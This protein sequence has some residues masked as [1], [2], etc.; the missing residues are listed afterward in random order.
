M[1]GVKEPILGFLAEQW[2]SM[3]PLLLP[4]GMAHGPNWTAAFYGKAHE[5]KMT[6]TFLSGW[7]KKKSNIL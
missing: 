3:L 4:L 6:F 5:L 1:E 7:E 2:Y